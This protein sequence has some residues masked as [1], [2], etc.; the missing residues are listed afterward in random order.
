MKFNEKQE[1]A[2]NEF[3][4][5]YNSLEEFWNEIQDL[6]DNEIGRL[7]ILQI[8][9]LEELLRY[10][11]MEMFKRFLES[12]GEST[13]EKAVELVDGFRKL[14][15]EDPSFKQYKMEQL[16]KYPDT[17]SDLEMFAFKLLSRSQ[18]KK[19][20]MHKELTDELEYDSL[21]PILFSTDYEIRETLENLF[22]GEFIYQLLE[23]PA[24]KPVKVRQK[25]AGMIANKDKPLII[26]KVKVAF[27]APNSM[28]QFKQII[29]NRFVKAKFA[30]LTGKGTEAFDEYKRFNT[31]ISINEV[32]GI[33][34]DD[35]VDKM[36]DFLKNMV[37]E[38]KEQGDSKTK[39]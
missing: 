35:F 2:V 24:M 32:L 9:A 6:Y 33:E 18:S 29:D 38:G 10:G 31:N 19:E 20:E 11:N 27:S 1:Q 23:E 3:I 8:Y 21:N 7:S 4:M 36:Y 22:I 14:L 15:D 25:E 17:L 13:E 37:N 34:K 28:S 30:I 5:K 16:K 39:K 26:E 12:K